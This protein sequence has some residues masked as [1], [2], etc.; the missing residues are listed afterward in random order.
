MPQ[1]Q[2]PLQIVKE[3]FGSKDKLIES[4]TGVLELGEGETKE[5]LA[6][7]LK[8]VANAKLLHLSEMAAQV[9]SLGGREAIVTKIAELKGQAKDSDFVAKLNTYSNGRLTDMYKS[10]S[11]KAKA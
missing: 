5:E 7:R 3:K 4:L 10:L 11:R 9:K 2:T 6:A 8:H 1:K